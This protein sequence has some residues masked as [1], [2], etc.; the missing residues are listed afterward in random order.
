MIDAAKLDGEADPRLW[1]PFVVVGRASKIQVRR[2][3][4]VLHIRLFSNSVPL[5]TI[6]APSVNA[7]WLRLSP[8]SDG[9]RTEGGLSFWDRPLTPTPEHSLCIKTAL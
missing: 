3:D 9:P 6:S 5:L 4:R 1:A 2:V 8:I 7:A